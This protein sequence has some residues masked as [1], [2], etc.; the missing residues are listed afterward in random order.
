MPALISLLHTYGPWIVFVNVLLEQAGVPV[1]AY[2]ILIIA[3]ALS[4]NGELNL[5]ACLG[6]AVLACLISDLGWHAAGRRFGK[7]ILALLC[8]LSLSPDYCVSHTED[9]F[10]R[11]G[12]KSLL[13][14]KFIPGFNTVAAP[15]SGAMGIPRRT[16][17]LFS[18]TGALLWAGAGLALGAL[19]H[20]SIDAMLN[21]MSTMGVAA[22]IGIGILLAMF[23]MYK[24]AQRRRFLQQL[25]MARISVTELR[26]LM[27]GGKDPVIVDARS[28][29]ARE[30]A[31]P[32]P[33]AILFG[34]APH[35]EAFD[36]VPRTHPI[37]VYCSCPNDASAAAVARQL[38]ARGFHQVRPLVGGLDAWNATVI[39]ATVIVTV[40]PAGPA[41]EAT[42]ASL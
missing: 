22:L 26:A 30:L 15:L 29:T 3:G 17:A 14:A 34:H 36:A 24:Y 41:I 23:L 16:F 11:W 27:D 18:V 39:D 4:A 10:S 42:V 9:I 37:V 32:I 40:A 21:I 12:V 33:G 38:A 7:R 2:P 6:A 35:A 8:R 31:P 5:G 1:P 25:R 20:E 13:V 19:F 28:I